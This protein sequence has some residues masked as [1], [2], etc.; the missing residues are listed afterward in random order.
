MLITLIG[1]GRVA[2]H[3]GPALFKA[4][5]RFEQVYSRTM[6]H[7]SEL[8]DTLGAEAVDQP[9]AIKPGADLYLCAL[10]DDALTTVLDEMP[11]NQWDNPLLVHTAGSL[12][13]SLLAP[14]TNRAG[15]LYPLQTFS[16]NRPLDLTSLPLFVEATDDTTLQMISA[17]A[18]DIS[19][20]V[21]P[22][23]SEKRLTLHLAAV[24][25]CNFVNHLY[26]VAG[27]LLEEDGLD[28][29]LL[30]PLIDETAA[31]VHDLA[32]REAQTGPAVRN[33]RRVIDKHLLLL[34]NHPEKAAL[35]KL[36]SE[37]IHQ[38]FL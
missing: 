17:L 23:A 3:L 20:V 14:Y 16:P 37:H 9:A 32:P 38:H 15:V 1:A 12:P 25:A 24:Y 6:A 7:A 5:H 2:N 13:L 8:A 30:L 28:F 27:E 35:Y 10:S 4:G 26:G 34:A 31:K 22:L 11:L 18:T 33:D 19:G 29:S 36:L 21:K